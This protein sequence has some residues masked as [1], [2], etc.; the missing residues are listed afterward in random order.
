MKLIICIDEKCGMLFNKRRQSRDRLLNEYILNMAEGSIA[1]TPYSAKMFPESEKIT[2]AEDIFSTTAEYAFAEE[3]IEDISKFSHIYIF[4]WN[5]KY[6]SDVRFEHNPE[7]LGFALES[8]DEF[9]GSS[10]EKITLSV[11]KKES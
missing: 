1:L 8:V 9:A 7:S 11:Y 5:R 6:P 2:V 4:N 10:H 3:R